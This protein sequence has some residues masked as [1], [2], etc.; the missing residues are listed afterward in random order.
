[1]NTVARGVMGIL[2]LGYDGAVLC[3]V[4]DEGWFMLRA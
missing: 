1:M 3:G 4:D 2:V